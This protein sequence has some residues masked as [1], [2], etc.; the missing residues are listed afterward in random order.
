MEHLPEFIANNTLLVL[1]FIVVAGLL[2]WN[3]FGAGLQG[4]AQVEPMQAVQLMNHEDAVVVD[5]REVSEYA[6]GHILN[7]IH[8]PLGGFNQNFNKL[9][10]YKQ[11]TIIINCNSGH[12]SMQACRILKKNGYEKVFNMRGG[13]LAWQ[14]SSLPITKNKSK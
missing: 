6:Q 4:L 3:F 1:S 2:A 13:I 8:I 9:D 5:V 10:K 7:S 11:G 12:R 14:N